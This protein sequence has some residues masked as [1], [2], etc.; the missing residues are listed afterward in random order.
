MTSDREL[1]HLALQWH[2]ARARR[3]AIGREKRRIDAQLRA[4]GDDGWCVQRCIEQNEA[5][6][7]LTELKRK[8]L[9]ALRELAKACAKQRGRLAGADVID[10]D[11]ATVVLPTAAL[12][13]LP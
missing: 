9:A 11:G 3:L 7:Q 5:G 2:T 10:V 13:D 4:G 6:R 1:I 8:E 12:L